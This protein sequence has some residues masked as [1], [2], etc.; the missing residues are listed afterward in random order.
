MSTPLE[1]SLFGGY[2]IFINRVADMS[3]SFIPALL[4]PKNRINQPLIINSS[5]K[6]L[7]L[8]SSSLYCTQHGIRKVCIGTDF[9]FLI[10]YALSLKLVFFSYVISLHNNCN[11]CLHTSVATSFDLGRSSILSL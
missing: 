8:F 10:Q 4:V 5:S 1:A 3:R 11:I 7:M 6:L 9:V 2:T